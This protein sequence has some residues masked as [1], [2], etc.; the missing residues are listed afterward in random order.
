MLTRIIGTEVLR[1]LS[2]FVGA[3]ETM[4]GGFRE[5]AQKTYELLQDA[6]ARRS[7]WSRRRSRT[8]C[9]RRRTSWTG[10]RPSP[11][12]WPGWC[13][14]GCARP[15]LPRLSAE[16]AD[17]AADA[18]AEAGDAPADRGRA[19][20]CTPTAFVLAAR[21]RR[22]RDRF[23]GA[24]PEVPLAEVPALATDVHDLDGLRSVGRALAAD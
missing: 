9:A 2:A 14:T 21:D 7:S 17:V 8:R 6:R 15:A 11:C 5:R 23:T 24:H 20:A 22:M 1:D 18:L 10:C 13:S 3:L 12:R 19:A 16:R 4:F